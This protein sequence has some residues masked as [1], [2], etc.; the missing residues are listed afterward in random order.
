MNTQPTTHIYFLLDRSGSMARIADDVI[1]GFNTFLRQQQAE[2]PDARITL[3]QFDSRDPQHVVLDGAPITEA[4]PLSHRTFIPRGGTPLLDATGLLMEK[5]MAASNRWLRDASTELSASPQSP[6][7]EH[8]LFVTLT[9][10]EENQSRFFTLARIRER[11][12]ER[13]AAGWSFLF[14]SAGPDAYG[15]AHRM[16]IAQDRTVSFCASSEGTQ[17]AMEHISRSAV[18]FRRERRFGAG[19]AGD[20][21]A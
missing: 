1:G 21:Q 12:A 15:E 3:V 10:G 7:A 9:D 14:L 5:A 11:I 16:G 4:T 6:M 17:R 8:I 2:G 13:T 19:K 20:G 18:E